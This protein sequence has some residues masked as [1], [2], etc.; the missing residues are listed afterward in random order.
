MTDVIFPPIQEAILENNC[1]LVLAVAVDNNG[2]IPTH[3]LCF[4]K[5]F[6]GDKATDL[7]GNGTKRIFDDRIALISGSRT[8]PYTLQI[9]RRDTGELMF[10]VSAPI[11]LGGI[12]VGYN[13]MTSH[14]LTLFYF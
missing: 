13:F 5:L 12:R 14:H 8:D 11:M 6:T 1:F 9:Y 2:Y 3:N 10:D 4:S 7:V